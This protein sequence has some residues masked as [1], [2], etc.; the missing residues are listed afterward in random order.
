MQMR[1]SRMIDRPC[2]RPLCDGQ[3]GRLKYDGG[4]TRIAPQWYRACR[5][6][7]AYVRHNP[8]RA[9][10]GWRVERNSRWA[11][12]AARERGNRIAEYWRS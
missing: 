11:A 6:C 3:L 4:T 1:S 9:E 8:N 5:T 2:P 7:G 12:E 10:G